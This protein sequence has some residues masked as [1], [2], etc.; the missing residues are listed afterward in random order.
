MYLL[1]ETLRSNIIPFK[2]YNTYSISL[3]YIFFSLYLCRYFKSII[4]S[5]QFGIN[6]KTATFK[7]IRSN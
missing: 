7:K 3:Q 6:Q 1:L 5:I 4:F 2:S